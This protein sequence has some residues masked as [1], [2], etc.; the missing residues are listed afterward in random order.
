MFARLIQDAQAGRLSRRGFLE[1]L[2]A[3][4]VAVATVDVDALLW[5]PGERAYV[6]TPGGLWYQRG[7]IIVMR[8][9]LFEV[10][11]DVSSRFGHIT[12]NPWRSLGRWPADEVIRA[13]DRRVQH[14]RDVMI[15]MRPRAEMRTRWASEH[16]IDLAEEQPFYAVPKVKA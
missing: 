2:M 13:T 5:T 1:S 10:A 14:A 16:R 9:G 7:E 15:P 8:T 12:I 4:G 3:G 6:Q 11:E